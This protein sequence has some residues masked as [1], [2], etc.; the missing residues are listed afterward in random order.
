MIA[1][2]RLTRDL[3]MLKDITREI[4][5]SEVAQ[6]AH[7]LLAREVRRRVVVNVNS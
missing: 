5:L 2:N 1:W 7:Q 4:D 3:S 6:T